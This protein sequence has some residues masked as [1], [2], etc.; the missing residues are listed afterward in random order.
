MAPSS[1]SSAAKVMERYR[2]FLADLPAICTP[3]HLDADAPQ[4]VELRTLVEEWVDQNR[5]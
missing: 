2:A 4:F 5:P 1:L 3:L